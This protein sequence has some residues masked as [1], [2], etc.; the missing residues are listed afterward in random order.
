LPARGIGITEFAR[1]MGIDPS[2]IHK[3]K[4]RDPELSTVGK[5]AQL[6]GSDYHELVERFHM[7][8]RRKKKHDE[9]V[10]GEHVRRIVE[11]LASYS[12]DALEALMARVDAERRKQEEG[13]RKDSER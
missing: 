9:V 8:G 11:E 13:N 2:T 10:E 5:A 1:Q 12:D 6:L 4:K 7:S 3:W